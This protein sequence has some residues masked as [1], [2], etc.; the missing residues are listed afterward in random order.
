MLS[1]SPLSGV[2]E[3]RRGDRVY[4]STL[5]GCHGSMGARFHRHLVEVLGLVARSR[6]GGRVWAEEGMYP[7]PLPSQASSLGGGSPRKSYNTERAKSR[8]KE[9]S[10]H[11][12]PRSE[13]HR[14][15]EGGLFLLVLI[16]CVFGIWHYS[17]VHS[18]C[19]AICG[20]RVCMNFPGCPP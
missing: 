11:Q 10:P 15:V 12:Q 7:C 1:G 5:R 6:G 4:P 3:C 17:N 20:F 16:V 13:V 19:I 18:T 14:P 8:T 9:T 2:H